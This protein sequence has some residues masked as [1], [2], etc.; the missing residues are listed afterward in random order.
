MKH[1]GLSGSTL[2]IL[3]CVFMLIDHIGARLLPGYRILRVIGRLAFPMFAFFIAE[4]CR[5]TRHKAKHFG[6]IF[7]FGVIW[8]AVLITYY[9]EWDGNIFLTFSLSVLLIYLWQWIKK[10]WYHRE[11]WIVLASLLLYGTAIGGVWL[12]TEHLHF[13]YGFYGV[14]AAPAAALFDYKDGEA[15][16]WMKRFDCLPVKLVLLSVILFLQALPTIGHG[17][18]VYALLAVIPL[19]FYNGTVGNRKLKYLFYVFYPAHLLV[20]H[21]VQRMLFHR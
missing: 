1:F 3:A 9:K 13:E 21:I 10:S 15:P 8:E 17:V 11:V 12:L 18:Q 5:Y 2:K 7:G 4:G 16:R 6:L 20:I 19:A 14:L